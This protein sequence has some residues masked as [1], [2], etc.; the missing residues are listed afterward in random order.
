[1]TSAEQHFDAEIRFGEW[2]LENRSY[3]DEP[4]KFQ[5]RH[6]SGEGGDFDREDFATVIAKFFAENF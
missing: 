4:D 3:A 2:I 5:I 6:A 1:M